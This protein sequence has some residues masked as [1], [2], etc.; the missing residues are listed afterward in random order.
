MINSDLAL[1]VVPG[2]VRVASLVF[3]GGTLESTTT[4]TLNTNRG[5]L[6]L[7]N[8][9]IN[10]DGSTVLTYNGV[11]A[12]TGA[13]NKAGTG[14][15]I[16]GGSNSYSGMTTVAFGSMVM[17]G[18]IPV[19]ADVV[20]NAGATYTIPNTTTLNT[21]TGLGNVVLNA[22][23][24]VGGST[25]FTFAGALSG[26]GS[27]IKTGTGTMSLS[28][29]NSFT[30]GITLN[31]SGLALNHANAL[32]TGI[33]TSSLGTLYE[34]NGVVLSSLHVSGPVTIATSIA[35][36][37]AQTYDGAVTISPA[38]GQVAN[39]V[40]YAGAAFTS[41]GINLV[42]NNAGITFNGTIDAAVAKNH[43][44]A[45]NAG[46]GTVTIGNSVGSIL[47][48]NN[49]N[50][51][52]ANIALL[53]DVK[54]SS[55]QN[56]TGATL[57]GN[58]GT[59]G[60]LY[61]EFIN[62]TRPSSN[63]SV[64]SQ[65]NTRTLMSNDPMVRF[66]GTVNPEKGAVYSLLVAA[67][68]NGFVNGDPLKEPRVIFTGLVGNLNS[69]YAVNF[70]ALQAGDVFALKPSA[71]VISVVGVQTVDTQNYSSN[72]MVINAPSITNTISTFR[73]SQ[74]GNIRFDVGA[75]GGISNIIADSAVTRIVI[76]GLTNFTNGIG[77]PSIS[78][79]VQ[80]A[81]AAAAAAAAS[82]GNWATALR[83]DTMLSS[84]NATESRSTVSVSMGDSTP[85]TTSSV[86][87]SAAT[88][89]GS[90]S[91]APATTT[92]SSSSKGFEFT[93][94]KSLMPS[95]SSS[96]ISG[97]TGPQ[98]APAVETAVMS[99]GSP[100]PNWIKFDPKTSTFTAKDVP[101]GTKSIEIKIQVVRDGKVVDE[102]KPIE[103]TAN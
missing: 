48:L 10:V 61:S 46:T 58:N 62:A 18:A 29:N 102:S 20:V 99:D 45:V 54:T 4:F 1:G 83:V 50:I 11:I 65:L 25:D 53:A 38:A 55:Q 34:G 103:I 56:Y 60:F 35:T 88:S 90:V 19:R 89:T 63:F 16:L 73:A 8:G 21:I 14:T 43:S 81:A 98:S 12:G 2:A 30:G 70:Q 82:G 22:N 79:P 77:L 71:G 96:S 76:D 37:G 86:A 13:F 41:T 6:L 40:D 36:A 24:T 31:N 27:L 9:T 74:P 64:Y 33:L 67:I 72:Q 57:I 23:L 69:F 59:P 94:P 52:A 7:G 28:G 3:N 80:E 91:A 51:T 75:V 5:I 15:L 87:A 39:L 100:L 101:A 95:S 32:G 97:S 26:A 17:N 47:P 49:F 92:E 93:I 78:F 66:V 68:Y 84:V 44:L 42:S 85:Q